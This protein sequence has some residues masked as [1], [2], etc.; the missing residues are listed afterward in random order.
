MLTKQVAGKFLAHQLT[1]M[2]L[3]AALYGLHSFRFGSLMQG[4]E[5]NNSVAF[6]RLHSDHKSDAIFGYLHLPAV[7]RF[8]VAKSLSRDVSLTAM[9]A[10]MF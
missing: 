7:R 9:R 6:L 5:G 10:G 1:S 8:G 4:L 3:N 2:G